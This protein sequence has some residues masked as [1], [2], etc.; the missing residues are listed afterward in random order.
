MKSKKAKIAIAVVSAV[1]IIILIAF[2][3][4]LPPTSGKLKASADGIAEK[5]YIDVDSTRLGMVL[6]G[7]NKNN[8]VLL[9]L[10]GGPGIPDY[11]LEYEYPS[12]M[13]KYFTLCYLS[14]RGTALSYDADLSK[15][16]MTTARFQSDAIAVTN[17]LRERFGQDKIYLMGHSFGT[18]VALRAAAEHP[19]LYKAYVGMNEHVRKSAA[20]G[21]A[22]IR[23]YALAV[24]K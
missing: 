16:A 3:V 7:E 19:E 6:K 18:T 8:P 14:Y 20:L 2:F 15:N 22:G 21:T 11:W 9:I 4:V 13:D 24:R 23:L 12:Q 10:G 17:Y 1:L 5:A